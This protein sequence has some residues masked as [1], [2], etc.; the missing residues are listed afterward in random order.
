MTKEVEA[1][2]RENFA[3]FTHFMMSHVTRIFFSPF[4]VYSSLV[5]EIHQKTADKVC[6]RKLKTTSLI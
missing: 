1:E 6:G 2:P 5:L 3:L 4:Y